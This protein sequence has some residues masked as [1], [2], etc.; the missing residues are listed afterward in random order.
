M[1]LHVQLMV[2]QKK[3]LIQVNDEFWLHVV[4]VL[5]KKKKIKRKKMKYSMKIINDHDF[6]VSMDEKAK[7]NI[8]N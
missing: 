8:I 7:T 2:Q 3:D 4:N 1:K 5:Q 6:V